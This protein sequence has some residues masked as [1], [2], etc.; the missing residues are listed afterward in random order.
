MLLPAKIIPFLQHADAHVRR[1]AVRYL[2]RA[3]DPTPATAD[4]LWAAIDR[5]GQG[6]VHE[7]HLALANMPQTDRSLQR[8]L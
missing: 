1:L 7:F 8:T 4:D 2:C 6:Q 5:F 3:N